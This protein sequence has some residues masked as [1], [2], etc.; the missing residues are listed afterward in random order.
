MSNSKAAKAVLSS[1]AFLAP[2]CCVL[3]NAA[4]TP[5]PT[6]AG[7][8]LSSTMPD[9]GLFLLS[10]FEARHPGEVLNYEWS[11]SP[12]GF[13]KTLTGNPLRDVNS[14]GDSRAPGA[15]RN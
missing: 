15:L 14:A 5:S 13:N 7:T 8:V 2:T 6:V 1:L 12:T 10:E 4:A 3:G 11:S 9:R